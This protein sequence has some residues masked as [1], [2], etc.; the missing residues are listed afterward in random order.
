MEVK[1]NV[2]TGQFE[3]F[4]DVGVE[5]SAAKEEGKAWASTQSAS[6]SPKKR[7]EHVQVGRAGKGR[8]ERG[9]IRVSFPWA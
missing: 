1:H 9:K 7:E 3:S 5:E 4:L 8:E 2:S 6:L